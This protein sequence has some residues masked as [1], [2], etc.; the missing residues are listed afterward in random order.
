MPMMLLLKIGT[1]CTNIKKFFSFSLIA[2]V[3]AISNNK[4]LTIQQ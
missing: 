2:I 4:A 1:Q 3:V